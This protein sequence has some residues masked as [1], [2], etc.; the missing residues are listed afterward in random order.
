MA[1]FYNAT[2]GVDSNPRALKNRWVRHLTHAKRLRACHPPA[3]AALGEFFLLSECDDELYEQGSSS[4]NSPYCSERPN[5]PLRFYP[6]K[7][8]IWEA[9]ECLALSQSGRLDPIGK[10]QGANA[11]S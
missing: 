11:H 2:H 9:P 4:R 7:K 1:G 6:S 5:I 10:C 8:G 3:Y